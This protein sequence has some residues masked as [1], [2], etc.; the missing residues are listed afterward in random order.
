M[1]SPK[2]C[3]RCKSVW[4][5]V[6]FTCI[7]L[8]LGGGGVSKLLLI[9]EEGKFSSSPRNKNNITA[10][11]MNQFTLVRESSH[12]ENLVYL[13][14]FQCGSIVLLT[15][16][17]SDVEK[18]TTLKPLPLQFSCRLSFPLVWK[19]LLSLILHQNF[20]TEFLH[21]TL[22]TDWISTLSSSQKLSF[23]S[24]F[25]SQLWHVHSERHTSNLWA[26]HMASNH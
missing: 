15:N 24:S 11:S 2:L 23:K 8:P 14:M 20:L 4:L 26:L 19:Y 1:H 9:W 3:T 25:F 10:V 16:R 17:F 12:Q 13:W 18:F 5:A 6:H 22:E 21:G 7:S